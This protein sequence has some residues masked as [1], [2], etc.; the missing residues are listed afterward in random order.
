MRPVARLRSGGG[1]FAAGEQFERALRLLSDGAFKVF[2]YICLHAERASGRLDFGQAELA[3]NLGKSRSAVGRHLGEMVAKGVCEIQPAP[4]QHRRS[5]LQVKAE[6]WPYRRTVASAENGGSAPVS[7]AGSSA[8]AAYVERVR[9]LFAGASCVQGAF[10]PADEH[11]AAK[12]HRDG[13]SLETFRRAFLLGCVRKS[14]A[15]IDRPDSQPIRSLG[16]FEPLLEEVRRESFPESYWQHVE[17]NLN[18][19]E[20]HWQAQPASAPGRRREGGQQ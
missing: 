11:L 20:Q 15:L 2:A 17:S 13:T 18:R 8:S 14:F 7:G 3:R 19:C 9:R 16:Y 5:R 10:S 1:W 6:F 12:W 4:N